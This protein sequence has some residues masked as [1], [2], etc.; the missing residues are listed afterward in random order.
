MRTASFAVFVLPAVGCGG[1]VVI[2]AAGVA[3]GIGGGLVN[4]LLIPAAVVA[5]L[6]LATGLVL[7]W[8]S[9]RSS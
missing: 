8:L 9:K 1:F 5:V 3:R 6:G 4:V 7:L 2:L